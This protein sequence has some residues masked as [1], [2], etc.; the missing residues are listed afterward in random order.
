MQLLPSPCVTNLP[1]VLQAPQED[2]WYFTTDT[3]FV[4]QALR[5]MDY[6]AS[7]V[8]VL[9][10][11]DYADT[12]A[13]WEREHVSAG[14][15]RITLDGLPYVLHVYGG[16]EGSPELAAYVQEHA[17]NK[18]SSFHWPGFSLRPGLWRLSAIKQIGQFEAGVQFEHA[19][20]LK[21]HATGYRVAFLPGAAAVHLAPTATWL[22]E[23]Q[24]DMD[25]V[26]ARHGLQLRHTPG[27][28]R[29]AYDANVAWR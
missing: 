4:T 25:A 13:A 11:Q 5:I 16:P 24:A 23:R 29:S 21:L 10:N 26:Y 20:G 1:A 27:H 6:D 12:D 19:F 17:G 22:Q 8:Q 28:Q 3:A 9:F 14:Q 7:I 2:D 15:Q 18:L